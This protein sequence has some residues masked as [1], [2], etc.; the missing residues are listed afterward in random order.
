MSIVSILFNLIGYAFVFIIIYNGLLSI[1]HLR[2]LFLSYFIGLS[3]VS[4]LSLIALFTGLDLGENLGR[5]FVEYWYGLPILLGTEDNPGAYATFFVLGI[6]IAFMFFLTCKHKVTKLFY[7]LFFIIF[8]FSLIITFSRSAIIGAILS[9][10]LLYHYRKN[11]DT[12]TVKLFI[13]VL[14]FFFVL[15]NIYFIFNLIIN[16]ATQDFGKSDIHSVTS[17]KEESI[18]VR[19]IMMNHIWPIFLENP[20]FGI[21][22]DNFSKFMY[23]ATGHRINSH[24]I[25]LGIAVEFGFFALAMFTT[26]I[27]LS[28]QSIGRTIRSSIC[29]IQR[30]SL[31]CVLSILIGLLF[32]G[33]FHEVYI[34]LLF[35]ITIA[36]CATSNRIS[37]I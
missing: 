1:K 25:F 29:C 20:W 23:E 5:P 27:I 4:S 7:A 36:F 14:L 11:K 12:V 30:L 21:G 19:I 34:N 28:L 37:M 24:N 35:W 2:Y 18:G 6:P 9:I 31:G 13:F 16:Y 26:I 32:H 3:I 17:N 8:C 15:A 22:Y 10:I 33:L